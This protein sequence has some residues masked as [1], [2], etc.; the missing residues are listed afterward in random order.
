MP[1]FS[2]V[3]SVYNKASNIRETIESVL[4]QSFTDYEIIVI[5]DASVDES[6]AIIT[7]ILSNKI[8]YIHLKKNVG[9]GAAR[10]EGIKAAKGTYISLLDGDDLWKN[11]Y[12]EEINLLIKTFPSHQ[13]YSTKLIRESKNKSAVC[14]YSVVFLDNTKHLD[15]DFFKSSYKKCILSSS[16]TTLHK[17]VFKKIG[18]YDPTIKSGQ[19]TDLWIRVGLNYRIA[20]STE[21]LVTYR[22]TPNSLYQSIS[23]IKDRL[24]LNKFLEEEKSHPSLKK[25]MDLNRYSLILRARLWGEKELTKGHLELL[26]KKNLNRKQ[27]WLLG[28]PTSMLKMAFKT[29]GGLEKLGVRLSAF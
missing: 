19:D 1:I 6:D 12:L 28:L 4:N 25:Y 20:F 10:N 5:N 11:N 24:D 14:Q 16:S 7:S 22:Y 23:S 15:L 18:V 8:N 29:Q 21:P 13:V 2:V 27:K 26:D 3:I 9:A 17:E